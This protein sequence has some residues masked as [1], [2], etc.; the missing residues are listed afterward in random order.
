MK[1]LFDDVKDKAKA[2]QDLKEEFDVLTDKAKKA[3]I[4]FGI[5]AVSDKLA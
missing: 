5:D 2:L 3:L 1:E 4:E